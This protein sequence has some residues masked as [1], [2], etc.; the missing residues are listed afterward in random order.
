MVLTAV[1]VAI[2]GVVGRLLRAQESLACTTSPTV[3][4]AKAFW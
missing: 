3:S 2:V 1:A 4:M